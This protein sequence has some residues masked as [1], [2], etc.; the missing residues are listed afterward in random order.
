MGWGD[1]FGEQDFDEFSIC[2]ILE[3]AIGMGKAFGI[4]ADCGCEGSITDGMDI[5]CAFTDCADNADVCGSVGLN[6]TF[7]NLGSVMAG[8]C[9]ENEAYLETCFH[10]EIPMADFSSQ[11]CAAS[12]GG[13]DCKCEI[14]DFCVKVDCSAYL[15]GAVMDTCQHLQI[16]DSADTA[17]FLLQFEIYQQNFDGFNFENINW[18]N[19]DWENLDVRNFDLDKIDWKNTDWNITQWSELFSVNVNEDVVFPFLQRAIDMSE[20]FA[21]NC[22]CGGGLEGG[23]NIDCSFDEVCT[24]ASLCGSVNLT[25]GFDNVGAVDGK[26]CVDFS[27]DAHLQTCFSYMIPIADSTSQPTCDAT[28]G[29]EQCGCEIDENFCVK[30]D[31][32]EYEP[33]AVTDS[34][35][36]ISLQDSDGQM[37]VPQFSLSETTAVDDG[38]GSEEGN[39]EVDE[40]NQATSDGNLARL[41]VAA[42]ALVSLPVLL[43]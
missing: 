3:R 5:S 1:L 19:I 43:M 28:Y 20:G 12:Y 30:I 25:F 41:S 38:D 9:F 37:M 27:N 35:Q 36:V 7:D 4:Q 34:C 6:F 39:K 15:P 40:A 21:S 24:D 26:A 33:T 10:Y 11:T 17:A 23:F 31:C 29:G 14:T 13:N 2:P 22:D 18:E 16:V 32:S 8:A 42:V